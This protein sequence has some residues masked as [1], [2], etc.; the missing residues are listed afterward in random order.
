MARPVI[1]ATAAEAVADIPDGATVMVGGFAARDA[2]AVL[3]AALAAH[4]ARNLT[5][6]CN[7]PTGRPGSSDS[8]LL[9]R[10]RQVR[11]VICS[12]PVP[13]T[14]SGPMTDFEA[15]YRAGEIELELTPQG[16]LAE[17]IRAGG[18]GLG[19]F[20]TPTGVGTPFAD[21]KEVRTINGQDYVFEYPL[22]ADYALIRAQT[23]DTMGN[24]LY[25]MA[26]RNFNPVMATA[27]RTTIVEV[28]EVVP[29][30]AL[31]PEAVVT[32]GLFV[33][34]IVVRPP[35]EAR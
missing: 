7:G 31:D 6:I 10:N 3:I 19:G 15:Q 13:S 33:H 22:V 5:L 24:L 16:T 18:A 32:P 12:F 28:A 11:K 14:T 4:G 25:R 27:A 35:E 2:P 30:G 34:R 29:A 23:A 8:S 20:Y 21:G 26:A 9:V 17:R 1:Y